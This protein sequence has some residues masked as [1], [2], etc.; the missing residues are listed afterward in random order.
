[1]QTT[2]KSTLKEYTFDTV[3]STETSQESVYNAVEPLVRSLFPLCCLGNNEFNA[4]R[5]KQ[6]STDST[7]VCSHTVKPV[8]EKRIQ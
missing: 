2:N 4:V 8:Q 7:H 3:F 1:M 6:W 5:L